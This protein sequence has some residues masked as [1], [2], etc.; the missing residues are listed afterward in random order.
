[1]G[2]GE[3]VAGWGHHHG[4]WVGV[5]ESTTGE[6]PFLWKEPAKAL[7]SRLQLPLGSARSCANM[8]VARQGRERTPG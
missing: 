3:V 2:V 6:G 4:H 8:A 5:D 7:A 1:M